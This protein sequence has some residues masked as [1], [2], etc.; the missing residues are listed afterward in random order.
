[1]EKWRVV[2]LVFLVI[3]ILGWEIKSINGATDPND[4]SALKGMYSSLNSPPQLAQWS[5]D[6][7]CGQSWTGITCSG[8]RVTEIKVAGLG[9]SGSIGFQLA[10]LTSVTNLDVSNNNIA[11]DIPYSLPPNLQQLNL[12]NNKFTGGLPY[13]ISQMTSLKYLNVG[14]N[15]LQNQLSDTFSQLSSLSTLDVSSNT[16]TGNL[17]QS[18]SLLSSMTTM[19]LQNNQFTGNIDVLANLPLKNLNVANNQ[20]TG[21]IPE[22][23]KS[24]DLQTG[25]NPWSSG[26][27]PPPPPGTPPANEGNRNHKSGGNDSPA[28]TG[29]GNQS[30]SSG[31]GGG[32]IAGIV[33]SLIVVGAVV[34]FFLV[35]RRS[36]RTSSDIEK[37]DSQPFAPLA[38]NEIHELKS[39]ETSSG[40]KTVTFDAPALINLRP[41]PTDRSKSFDDE[42]VSRKPPIVVKKAVLA[43]KKINLSA[44]RDDLSE[45]FVEIVSNISSLHHPNVTELVGYCSEHGQHLLVYEFHNGNL[46]DFLHLSEE[47]SKPLTWNTRVKIA[48]GTARALE[49]LHEVC[50]LS[51]IHKNV[52][53]TNILLDTELNPH[54]SDSGLATFVRNADQVSFVPL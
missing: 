46:H 43:V 12:A 8:S 3:C 22:Q 35:K 50:S 24:I 34:A 11:G 42:D 44:F 30:K 33:I 41:P 51:I 28:G 21:W 37:L 26:P 47:N 32:G 18:L 6:D 7:P 31:I 52:K 48:L 54:L 45:D 38:S 17:P 14:Q 39:V 4:V 13:S 25:G 53:S 15:Q 19:F 49:Y 40:I 16:M 10:G 36:R 20:F 23:L 29:A 5:G 2:K 27:A 1:M 9:L